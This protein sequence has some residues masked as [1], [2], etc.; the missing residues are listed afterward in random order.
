MALLVTGMGVIALWAGGSPRRLLAALQHPA[1]FDALIRC[2]A[3]SVALVL[4]AWFLFAIVGV[5]A[6]HLAA[7]ASRTP[8]RLLLGIAAVLD[9]VTPRV[10]RRLARAAV[11]ATLA[12]GPVAGYSAPS[13]AVPS[14]PPGATS[15]SVAADAGSFTLDWPTVPS[16]SPP[17]A[18]SDRWPTVPS[19]SPRSLP[20][21][22]D[23]SG[24]IHVVVP[25]DT[26]WD[27]AGKHLAAR[28]GGHPPSAAAIAKEWPRWYAANRVIIGGD[29]NLLFPGERLQP[30]AES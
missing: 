4:C 20:P 25:G 29:P 8:R 16:S 2:V 18:P 15:G 7:A 21:P 24:D 30:P 13:W 28:D 9:R 14:A 26:L 23:P 11:G 12:L 19:G 6:A 17:T 5:L 22:D 3:A 27:I 10:I 1:D